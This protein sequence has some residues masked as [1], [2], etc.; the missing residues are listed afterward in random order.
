MGPN[1]VHVFICLF[2]ITVHLSF[3][4]YKS[5]LFCYTFYHMNFSL[6]T[7]S[8]AGLLV[9]GGSISMREQEKSSFDRVEKGQYFKSFE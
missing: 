2:S 6:L 4:F 9:G 1:G 3:H 7:L 8:E 5:L